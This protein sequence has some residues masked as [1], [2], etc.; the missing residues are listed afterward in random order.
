MYK[1]QRL[2]FA[3]G[4][5]SQR[6]Q[7]LANINAVLA[8]P[9]L[10][11]KADG[12]VPTGPLHIEY[13]AVS[14]RY[15]ERLALDGVSLRAEA[16][17]LTALVGAS[18]SGKS[19]LAR[20]LPRLYDVSAGAVRVGGRDVRDWPLD[21]LLSQMCIRD[22]GDLAQFLG[23]AHRHDLERQPRQ[24]M[25]LGGAADQAHRHRHFQRADQGAAGVLFPMRRV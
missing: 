8:E 11:D 25:G 6:A 19:T 2:T 21:P 20:L 16:G 9:A 18:G 14:H 23:R 15:G 12:P 1:R 17:R 24:R 10:A 22:S 4:E 7:A 13:D 3:L 5:Q